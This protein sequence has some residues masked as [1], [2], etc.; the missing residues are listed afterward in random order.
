M[1]NFY[2]VLSLFFALF[3]NISLA[4]A[5]EQ[6]CDDAV[7]EIVAKHL[8]LDN[9]FMHN[10][11]D[12]GILVA[13]AC[14]PSPQDKNIVLATFAYSLFDK[15][16]PKKVVKDHPDL[17]YNKDLIVAMIDKSSKRVTSSYQTV[18]SEDAALEVG[19][20][21]LQL[22]IAR[23]ELELNVRAFG[24][25][26]HNAAHG[27]SCGGSWQEDE[28][29]LFVKEGNELRPVLGL[30]MSLQQVTNGCINAPMIGAVFEEAT[31]TIGVEKAGNRGYADLLLTAQIKGDGVDERT[32]PRVEHQLLHYDGKRYVASKKETPWWLSANWALH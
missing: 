11:T 18:I 20:D 17:E 28:L 23:Y 16:Q 7:V 31:L 30:P 1:N 22:D 19:S 2:V 25:R 5:K 10:K 12:T 3:F 21:S 15:N 26:F 27:P 13:E 24:L 14:K 4:N 8:K 29:A 6:T 9:F 32:K